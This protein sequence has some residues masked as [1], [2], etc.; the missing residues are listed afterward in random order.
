MAMAV[1]LK[2]LS[3]LLDKLEL[4]HTVNEERSSIELVFDTSKFVNTEG[5]KTVFVVILP[6]QKGVVVFAPSLY[7]C[8]DGANALPTLRAT[9]HASARTEF[10]GYNCDL[11]DGAIHAAVA[12]PLG[13]ADLSAEQL[14]MLVADV[15]ETVDK[16][17]S[18]IQGAIDTGEIVEPN[19]EDDVVADTLEELKSLSPEALAR[20]KELVSDAVA[21]QAESGVEE[22]PE[23]L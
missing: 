4:K 11:E 19:P 8:P 14:R 16:N 20:L 23:R 15:L 9:F 21:A 2:Q 17:H 7:K 18:M 13:R 6:K 10:G 12:M 1:T 3:A 22:E 5:E